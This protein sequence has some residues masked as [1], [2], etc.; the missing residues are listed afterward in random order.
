MGEFLLT[1]DGQDAF[2]SDEGFPSVA[3]EK[4]WLEEHGVLVAATPQ[5]S[6]RRAWPEAVCRWAAGKRQFIEGVSSA[7]SRVLRTVR[8]VPGKS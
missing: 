3:W 5:R 2:L 4:H 7:L 8:L 6:S 1:S